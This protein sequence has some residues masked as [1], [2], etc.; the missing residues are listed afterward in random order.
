MIVDSERSDRDLASTDRINLAEL[1]V[2]IRFL[3]EAIVDLRDALGEAHRVTRQDL[4]SF[5]AQMRE[6]NARRDG[7]IESL[8]NFRWWIMGA[9]IGFGALVQFVMAYIKPR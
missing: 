8:Q 4:E 2:E 3:K 6:D 7:K 1:R 5:R 9:S